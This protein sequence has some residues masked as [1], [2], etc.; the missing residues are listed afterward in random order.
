MRHQSNA[1]AIKAT[2]GVLL[3]A[4]CLGLCWFLMELSPRTDKGG[5]DEAEAASVELR[6]GDVDEHSR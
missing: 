3:F 4:V 2:G 5:K 1:S 6:S